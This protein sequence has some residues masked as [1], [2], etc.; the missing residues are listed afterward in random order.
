M[1]N[2]I[3]NKVTTDHLQRN[4]YLYIRQST[5]RQVFE[6]SES[7]KRQYALREK[8]ISLGWLIENIIV[9]DSDLGQSGSSIADRDGFKRLVTEVGLGNAGIVLGL[10][11]SRLARNCADWHRLLEICALTKTLI[12][13]EEG[14]YDPSH[15]NDRLLLGLKGTMSEAE[16]HV[17]KARLLGGQRNKAKRGELK[18]PVPIGFIYS[19]DN[20][21]ILDPDLQIRKSI[22]L[23]FQTFRTTGSATA[24]VKYFRNNGIKFPCKLLRGINKGDVIWVDLLHSRALQILHNPRYA[25][26]YFW[27][28][29]Q[30]KSLVNGKKM[31]KKL[32]IEKWCVLHKNKHK[33][34]IS[35]DE[36]E[37]NQK[38]L[39]DN[40]QAIGFERRKSPPREGPALIQGIIICGKCGKRM[41]VRYHSHKG[42]VIPEYV[43]QRDGVEYAKPIC[44]NIN[45]QIIDKTIGDIVIDSVN[46]LSLDIT[47]QIHNELK[48]RHHEIE[49][50]HKKNVE[51][52][53]YESD[54]ARRRYMQVDPDNRL[55]ADTLEAEWNK[56]LKELTL[57]QD[58]FEKLRKE[59]NSGPNKEEIASIMKLVDNLPAVWKNPKTPNREKKRIVRMI[60]DDVTLIRDKQITMHIRFKGGAT[61]SVSMPCPVPLWEQRV[62]NKTTV[63]YIDKLLDNHTD[64]ETAKILNEN[65]YYTATDQHFSSATICHIR[66]NYGLKNHRQRL[67]DNGMITI[68]E[69]ASKIGI[70]HTS[71]KK[72]AQKG[73]LKSFL[74]VDNGERYVFDPGN[75]I[76]KQINKMK[77]NR[78]G[79]DKIR[80]VV[81]NHFN[82]VQYET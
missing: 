34:Y 43:C 3:D 47:I 39:K 46:P 38:R 31:Y 8:A 20:T 64:A 15:F 1:L 77:R 12:L 7:T 33:G 41:T 21:V 78:C 71:L 44:Q 11:V 51:R 32:D 69:A 6:N 17:I 59:K 9:I 80:E 49:E 30:R 36:F 82:E 79:H 27:G 58:E 73:L 24:T 23:F 76:K 54:L 72:W 18:I 57:V 53:K 37:K 70:H 48:K 67:V 13:D 52:I 2:Y 25:G 75:T 66:R 61:R 40:S 45:G 42:V 26:A 5:I 62:T 50:I 65:G 55:V 81:I 10:E 22:I 4:A 19:K 56:K 35:W 14:I 63:S 16:L 28:R 68:S 29:I 60:I 74:G